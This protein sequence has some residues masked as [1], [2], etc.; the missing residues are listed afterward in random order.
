[1]ATYIFFGKYTLEGMKGMSAERTKQAE[2]I[3]KKFD[4]KVKD[5]Y[6]LLGPIDIVFIAEFPNTEKAM[7][8]S[9]ALSKLTS[10]TFTT[11]PAVTIDE[12]DKLM[13]KI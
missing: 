2:D 6:A 13:E 12:F 8:T 7:Q 9:A 5:G 1:M 3:V 10:I 4:C 11:A